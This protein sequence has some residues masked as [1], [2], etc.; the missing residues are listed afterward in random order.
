MA[1]TIPEVFANVVLARLNVKLRVGKLATDYTDMAPDITQ[2]GDTIHF[3]VINRITDAEII[4]KGTALT[5]E[6]L[7]M[8]DSTATIKHVGKAER[9][10]DVDSI[11]VKGTVK[12]KL[13][14]ALADAMAKAVDGDLVNEIR[15]NAVYK[16]STLTTL[17]A[18][19]VNAAFEV[20]GDDIDNDTFAGIL[21][22]P[23]LRKYFT[24]MDEF[25]SNTKTNAVL[26]NG[27]V[28]DGCIG[29]WNGS[30]PVIVSD[31]G[32][33][34]NGKSMLAIIKNDAIGVIWQKTPSIEEEREATLRAT[35]LVTDELYAVKLGQVDGVSVLEVGA[36]ATAPDT[37]DTE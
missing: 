15:E 32:T 25:M 2:C 26:G 6:D 30:I 33:Y 14:T 27:V 37:S 1:I 12:D 35:V 21:I 9:L 16:D 24:K 28:I 4:E 5:P 17:T 31:N 7:S 10:Y 11:Q 3:P 34:K 13:A 36:T 20:F 23:R 8:S 18:D 29:Y 22:N 19:D